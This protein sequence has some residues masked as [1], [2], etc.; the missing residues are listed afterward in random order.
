MCIRDRFDIV[1]GKGIS[2]VGEI[3]DLAVEYDIIKKSGAW[4]AYGDAKI[5]Q[6]REAAK[7]FLEDNPEV[8]LEIENKVKAI[9]LDLGAPDEPA[10][11]KEAAKAEAKATKPAKADKKKLS[12]NG[13]AE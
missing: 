8:S 12:K 4:Y 2:K 11:K 9:A 6:G 3:V 5:A 1:F 10:P 13:V 7:R